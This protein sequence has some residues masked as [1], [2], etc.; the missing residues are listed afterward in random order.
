ME[1]KA[2]SPF[3]AQAVARSCRT[4]NRPPYMACRARPH[5]Q[6]RP[7]RSCRSTGLRRRSSRPSR[8]AP[9]VADAINDVEGLLAGRVGLRLDPSLRARLSQCVQ[10]EADAAGLSLV[11]YAAHVARDP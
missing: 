1:L 10:E 6:A 9:V 3:A 11:K 4:S 8:R 7:N 5:K 2:C